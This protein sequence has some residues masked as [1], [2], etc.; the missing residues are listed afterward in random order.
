MSSPRAVLFDLGGVLIPWPRPDYF[1]RWAERFG[2]DR[3]RVRELLF[4]SADVEAANL[5]AI[6]AEEYCR[7]CSGRVAVSEE[8]ILEL[9]A[10]AFGG[11]GLN[12]PLVSYARALGSRVR[13]GALTNN[14][15]F[16]RSILAR[17]GIVDL[18]E[19]IVNSAEEGVQKPDR[20]IYQ[21]ALERLGL[22]A[23]DVVFVDDREENVVA[24]RVMGMLGVQF[25]TTE[26]TIAELDRL[27][28]ARAASDTER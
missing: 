21:I 4:H 16:A 17:R 7:R 1:E 13:V 27:L 23:S 26:Q 25:L 3:L 12:E 24:A 28:G 6:T 2:V 14:W 19:V 9:L 10:G 8:H 18:F 11:E 15:S 22:P 20:R 5:G